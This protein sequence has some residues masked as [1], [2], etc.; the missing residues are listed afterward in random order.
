MIPQW[1]EA[2]SIPNG[3]RDSSTI[4]AG[5]FLV[6]LFGLKGSLWPSDG[7][8]RAFTHFTHF[9]LTSSTFADDF[10]DDAPIEMFMEDLSGL[11]WSLNYVP[12][13]SHGLACSE[14]TVV[15]NTTAKKHALASNP[16]TCPEVFQEGIHSANPPRR[17]T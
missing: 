13:Y 15:N 14:P 9:R 11:A 7:N 12:R 16:E 1:L 4:R 8:S 10:G 17:E 6:F 3:I 2:S 5:I